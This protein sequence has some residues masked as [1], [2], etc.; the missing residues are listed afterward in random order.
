MRHFYAASA[1]LVGSGVSIFF[2]SERVAPLMLPQLCILGMTISLFLG[3]LRLNDGLD[4]KT[5]GK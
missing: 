5:D 3:T 1:L 4:K 2:R